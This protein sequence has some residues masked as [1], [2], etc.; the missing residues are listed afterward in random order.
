VLTVQNIWAHRK[1][2]RTFF[3]ICVSVLLG[4]VA[5]KLLTRVRG[6]QF[7]ADPTSLCFD[8]PCSHFVARISAIESI[9][10]QQSGV[11]TYLVLGDSITE[12]AELEPICGRKPL[13]AGIGWATSE[14]FIS[15]GARLAAL[16]HPDFIVVA[17]GTNDAIRRKTEFAERITSL[18]KS[19]DRYPVILVPLPG[20]SGVPN[21]GEYNTVLNGFK[22]VARTLV[23]AK[24]MPD[25]IHL[26]PSAYPEWRTS[27]KE[28]A[29]P[30]VCPR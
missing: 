24:T 15:Q 12:F 28:I 3:V 8:V 16:S 23:S 2:M 19:L 21:A 18:V 5:T 10:G 6:D 29:E 26:D 14:T 25:G 1:W 17:L 4:A 11:P 13:N 27:I 30:L 20:G 22:N 7:L 9:F